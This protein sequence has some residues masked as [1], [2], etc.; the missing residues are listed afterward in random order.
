MEAATSRLP[1]GGGVTDDVADHGTTPASTAAVA[2][3][4]E[5][6]GRSRSCCGSRA[7]SASSPS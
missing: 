5:P 6:P 4:C 7:C 2:D 1:G 3:A